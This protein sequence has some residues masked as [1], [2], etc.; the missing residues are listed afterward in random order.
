MKA[1]ILK[2]INRHFQSKA[3]WRMKNNA[4]FN[5]KRK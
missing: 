5:T 4:M 3:S 2:M 1:K